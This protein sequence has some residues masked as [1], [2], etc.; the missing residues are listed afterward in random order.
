MYK[1]KFKKLECRVEN[2]MFWEELRNSSHT[3]FLQRRGPMNG[4][5]Q[6]RFS[7]E[8]FPMCH[9]YRNMARSALEKTNNV[10]AT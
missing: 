8:S 9:A 2:A 7:T 4:G 5:S 6:C 3:C 10:P 1:M